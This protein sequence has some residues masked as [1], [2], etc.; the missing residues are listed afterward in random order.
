MKLGLAG[1]GGTPPANVGG[2]L[3]MSP[4]S[5]AVTLLLGC[6]AWYISTVYKLLASTYFVLHYTTSPA[7]SSAS[8]PIET[9]S[10]GVMPTL[11][12]E[13]FGVTPELVPES[14]GVTLLAM[15]AFEFRGIR[16]ET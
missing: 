7:T 13:S 11:I 9:G 6:S 1:G 14:F 8:L 10:L 5:T 3:L 15:A 2:S 4:S 12:P 16:A